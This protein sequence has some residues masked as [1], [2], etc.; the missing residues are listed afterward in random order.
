MAQQDKNIRLTV[1][2]SPELYQI[3]EDLS[4]KAHTSKSEIF[5]KGLSLMELAINAKMQG[6]KLGI[7][8]KDRNVLVEIV[9]I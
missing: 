7:T 1:E 6:Q 2:I 4:E 3:L 8:D 5:R 9:G